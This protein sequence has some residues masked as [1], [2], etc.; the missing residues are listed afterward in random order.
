MKN[1]VKPGEDVTK[2][3]Q[4]KQIGP[5]GGLSYTEVTLVKGNTVPPTDK[6]GCG[7]VL[8]DKTKHK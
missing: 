6:P 2:S 3:G 1:V 4:Y 5:R 7:Y 8:V